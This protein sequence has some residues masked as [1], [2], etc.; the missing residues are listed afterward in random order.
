MVCINRD[1]NATNN[2]IKLVNYF[3]ENKDRLQKFK[4]YFKFENE[5]QD[6]NPRLCKNKLASNIVKPAKV[7][8]H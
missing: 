4:R 3:L 7:Q 8:L 2:M 5:I 1:G 6:D